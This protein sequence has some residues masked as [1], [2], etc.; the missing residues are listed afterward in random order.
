VL[1]ALAS[2]TGGF[3][4]MN[5][6]DL[7][8]GLQKI[9]REQNEYYV[10]GY[11]PEESKEGSCHELKVKVDR[12]GTEVRAR[13]GYCTTK[14]V[15]YLAGTPIEKSL[16]ARAGMAAPGNVKASMTLPFFYT[17][18]N[19]ARVNV[20]MEIPADTLQFQKQKGKMHGEMN[21]LGIITDSQGDV[22]ARF[23]DTVKLEFENK[24]EVEQFQEHPMHYQTQFEVGAGNYVCKVV[25]SSGDE[26]FGKV[27]TPL[28]IDKYDNSKF[29][30]SAVALSREL[31]KVSDL[32]VQLDRAL[33]EDRT[34][35]VSRGMELVPSGSLTFAKTEPA[36]AYL[37]VYEPLLAAQQPPA[38]GF[39]VGIDM[40]FVDQKTGQ[41]KFETG[42]VTLE[43]F[44]KPGNAL[45]AVG[46]RLPLEK[47]DPGSYRAEFLAKDTAGNT[48]VLRSADLQVR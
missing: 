13:S 37:E 33:L 16:E 45:I 4:I 5:T 14:P 44:I 46:M 19:T 26:T 12:G 2:G 25:F 17:S 18:T 40:R 22:A 31:H 36:A 47:L 21:V 23:S 7:L 6:N 8:G 30:M 11:T 39:K 28:T 10:L 9:G 24:K 38:A 3:V 43:P 15:D 48:S 20:A 41:P 35:L 29:G 32:D 34:P 42:F 1:Y 27:E